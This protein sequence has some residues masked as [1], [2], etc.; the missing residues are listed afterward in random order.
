M[1]GV[2]GNVGHD[3]KC[4]A[5]A[6]PSRQPT[7]QNSQPV[8]IDCKKIG[9][10]RDQIKSYVKLSLSSSVEGATGTTKHE[11]ANFPL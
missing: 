1:L 7:R 3:G 2:T 11:M 8:D 9:D 5:T 10:L 4:W 6:N